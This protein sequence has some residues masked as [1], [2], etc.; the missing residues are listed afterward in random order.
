MR[1]LLFSLATL[2]A[3]PG[4]ALAANKKRAQTEKATSASA[5]CS[6]DG[7]VRIWT[8]PAA[9]TADRAL[10]VMVVW[11]DR[12]DKGEIEL[13]ANGPGAG[14]RAALRGTKRG[15]PPWSIE[16]AVPSPGVGRHTI[17]AVQGGKVAACKRIEVGAAVK[18]RP[19]LP[20]APAGGNGWNTTRNWDRAAEAFYAAFVES[21]FDAPAATSLSFPSLAPALR[22]PAR[23]FFFDHL[24]LG[25][26]APKGKSALNAVPDCADL[27]YFTRAYFS[28]K[29]GLP[30]GMRDCDRG[31]ENRPPRCG[32][33]V[34]NETPFA[35]IVTRPRG[36]GGS[37]AGG[38]AGATA[39]T[40][41]G[42]AA[43]ATSTTGAAATGAA[44]GAGKGPSK[45]PPKDALAAA[46]KFFR[47][48][49]NRVHSGSARTGLADEQ[50]DY[51]PVP[52]TREA[53]RPGTVYADPYGHV[54]MLVKWVEQAG[55]AGGVLL[56]VDGQPDNSVGRKRFWEGTFLYAN[57]VPSAGA[58]W[59]AFRPLVRGPDGKLG[60][61]TNAA[62][63]GG[64]GKG[65]RKAAA[66]FA[67]PLSTEQKDLTAE[68]FYARM[69][70]VINPRGLDP[71]AAYQETLNALVEQL[72]TRV[73]SVD[74][75]EKYMAESKGAVVAMPEGAKIF[76]TVGAWED[77][78]TPSRDMRLLIA[79]DVLEGLPERIVRHPELFNLGDKKPEAARAEVQR[80]H[81]TRI[82]ERGVEYKRS[83][84]TPFKLTVADVLARKAG[85]EMTYNPNDCVEVRWAAPEGS[86]EASTCRRRAPDDQRKRMSGEFRSWFHSRRRPSR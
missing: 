28:W 24:G 36:G 73:G 69:G 46:K 57:D 40:G 41:A 55:N 9:P 67:A 30:F 17:E 68:A 12:G 20:A 70:K 15:G 47:L 25:E 83:D 3:V 58:G 86:P 77:Y 62:L 71:A 2:V 75:G 31:A 80:L 10:K 65:D 60:A 85:F 78:A 52:L 6:N 35:S 45:E 56:A 84:G 27:P 11:E 43:T 5:G 64:G 59:K 49:A 44:P 16:A 7:A 53:L 21:L 13:M 38:G 82:K 61:A 37:G 54:L 29:L 79:V 26:D 74:N 76:E 8:A 22:D 39:A 33:L 23:N 72:E 42:A 34:T 50:T 81:A 48:L 66:A 1:I 32:E 14:G 63:S 18:K 51:Y 4:G 19:P